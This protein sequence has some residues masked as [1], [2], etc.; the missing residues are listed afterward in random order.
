MNQKLLTFAIICEITSLGWAINNKPNFHY[1]GDDVKVDAEGNLY[2]LT[3]DYDPNLNGD[4]LTVKYNKEGRKIWERR[5]DGPIHGHDTGSA[6][7]VD[8]PGNVYVTGYVQLRET[9]P[10]DDYNVSAMAFGYATIKYDK[11]GREMWAATYDESKDELL[12]PEDIETDRFGNV[13]VLSSIEVNVPGSGPIDDF[14]KPV[15]FAVIKYDSVGKQEW[16]VRYSEPI[17]AKNYPSEAAV[18]ELGNV[19]VT[20][21]THTLDFDGFN[22]FTTIKYDKSGQKVWSAKYVHGKGEYGSKQS[23][24]IDKEGGIYVLGYCSRSDKKYSDFITIKYDR[25]GKQQWM[26]QYREPGS[27]SVFPVDI[28]LDNDGNVYI[29]GY[30]S[31]P[32]RRSHGYDDFP[33]PQKVE[34]VTV[35]YNARGKEQWTAKYKGAKRRRGNV[36]GLGIDRAGNVYVKGYVEHAQFRNI[37]VGIVI[38]YDKNGR[39]KWI[40][41]FEDISETAKMLRPSYSPPPYKVGAKWFETQRAA[42]KAALL[43]D[44][45][46][47]S[48]LNS[49]NKH[50]YSLLGR[51]ASGGYIDIIKMLIDKGAKVTDDAVCAGVWTGQAE[52]VKILAQVHGNITADTPC[53]FEALTW[54]EEPA[55]V[56]ALLEAGLDANAKDKDGDSLLSWSFDYGHFDI[57]KLLLDAGADANSR[58]SFGEPLVHEALDSNDIDIVKSFI[59]A[60]VSVDIQNTSGQSLLESAVE[61][62]NTDIVKLLLDAGADITREKQ[63]GKPLFF[64]AVD[65]DNVEIVR[66]LIKGGV[67]PSLRDEDGWTALHRAIAYS[68]KNVLCFL[69][70]S[71]LDANAKSADGRTPLQFAIDCGD[72]EK[73]EI[74]RKYG[75]K[76]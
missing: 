50:G 53:M 28:G 55:V 6:I 25:T 10:N 49:K 3:N 64:E 7:T 27:K 34:F 26:A 44:I 35:K 68:S 71:G 20:G 11:N 32:G 40:T 37:H 23:L 24:T 65:Q 76:E 14:D 48:D 60:G 39:E 56:K 13:Y 75:A 8:G 33:V 47:S 67:D 54:L 30:V 9:G 18:D 36:N 61:E 38:K 63:G 12:R 21:A 22:G 46:K 41:Y 73:A 59:D 17:T 70:E 5:F 1:F 42:N 72:R 43:S 57:V 16:S 19:Y 4:F 45:R 29:T 15:H 58:D 74:L 62:N 66:L 69:L 51:A 2:D 52:A 31:T